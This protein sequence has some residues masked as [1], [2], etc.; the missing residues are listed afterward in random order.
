MYLGPRK[1]PRIVLFDIETLPNLV[2][3]FDM[4]VYNGWIHPQNIQQEKYIVCASWRYLGEKEV[5]S[6]SVLDGGGTEAIP[7]LGI[8]KTVAKVFNN[9]DAVVAHR[10]DKF[11]V[12]WVMART[13]IAG[14]PPPRPIIQIDTLKIA[15]ARF[16]F[17][18]NSL[19]YLAQ[20][21]GVG[22]KIQT[23]YDLWPACMKGDVKAIND[24]VR[25]NRQDVRVLERVYLRL[26]P[27]VPPKVN[28]AL[29][30]AEEGV[31][32]RTCPTCNAESLICKGSSYT[33][34]GIR[35]AF[36]CKAAGCHAWSYKISRGNIAR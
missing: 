23:H 10:G 17:N 25:Y 19:D 6:V 30:A 31:A 18:A 20:L 34:T 28:F 27:F 8:L 4:K 14:L 21:L 7:D 26:R 22:K 15:K 11:D 32:G 12:P 29:W 35:R 13:V 5:Y 3:A 2:T 1:G 33:R 16:L 24:M 36:R 9:C